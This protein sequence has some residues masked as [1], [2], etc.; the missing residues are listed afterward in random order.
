MAGFD[1]RNALNLAIRALTDT[2]TKRA[3]G[4]WIPPKERERQQRDAMRA[5]EKQARQAEKQQ[6]EHAR[7]EEKQQ[8][9]LSKQFPTQYMPHVGR[10]VMNTGGTPEDLIGYHG[11]GKQFESF[12]PSLAG[13]ATGS[14]YGEAAGYISEQ[15]PVAQ[16]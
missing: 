7:S 11:S 9:L 8:K 16:E 5:E 15:E 10:Q 12:D 14:E 1:T 6:K 2:A 3:A 13:S 4:G